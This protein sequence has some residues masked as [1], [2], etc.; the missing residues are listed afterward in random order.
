MFYVILPIY[1]FNLIY[2]GYSIYRSIRTIQERFPKTEPDLTKYDELIEKQKTKFMKFVVG[3]IILI[4][5]LVSVLIM[6]A[7]LLSPLWIPIWIWIEHGILWGIISMSAGSILGAVIKALVIKKKSGDPRFLEAGMINDIIYIIAIYM[8]GYIF[9]DLGELSISEMV[10]QIYIFE[11]FFNET[12]M[13]LL[14]AAIF[15]FVITNIYLLYKRTGYVFNRDIRL[16]KVTTRKQIYIFAII[17]SFMGLIY[18]NEIDL[19]Y[20]S[21]SSLEIVN[22][23]KTLLLVIL[24]AML[25]PALFNVMNKNGLDREERS[26]FVKKRD[27]RKIYAI[28]RRNR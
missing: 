16:Y 11:F 1:V 6:I 5:V 20:V 22:G 3:F 23:A 15:A 28:R 21:T 14:P 27:R 7:V 17:A 10:H 24:T 8:S 4:I 12:L 9:T 19:S 26:S 13:V 25:I 18:F 2:V